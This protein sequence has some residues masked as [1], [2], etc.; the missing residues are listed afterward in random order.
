MPTHN[1]DDL[2]DGSKAESRKRGISVCLNL[3]PGFTA[4]QAREAL[5][6][7][8]RIINR[9]CGEMLVSGQVTAGT[10]AALGP[11]LEAAGRLEQASTVVAGSST[12]TQPTLMVPGAGPVRRQ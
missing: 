3:A 8:A 7:M 1:D 11:M 9:I 12:L 4:S 5:I 10:S 2:N 6:E